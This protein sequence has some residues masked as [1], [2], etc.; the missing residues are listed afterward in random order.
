MAFDER[1]VKK[2]EKKHGQLPRRRFDNVDTLE[3]I[4]LY[5]FDMRHDIVLTK[6][7]EDV[8]KILEIADELLLRYY[9]GISLAMISSR[10]QKKIKDDLH[11]EREH[12]QCIT[13]VNQALNIF[14]EPVDV[15]KDKK[16]QLYIKRLNNIAVEAEKA[17]EY[18]AAVRALTKAAEIENFNK[19]GDETLK[20]LIKETNAKDIVFTSS[21]DELK[22][23]ASEIMENNA[24]DAQFE[25]DK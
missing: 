9:P 25:E 17:G 11:L 2:L 22:K 7:E 13:Y 19:D 5:Y 12:R 16:R 24:E 21:M 14:G 3:R 8:R 23:L 18:N 1:R 4:W 20:E 15:D 6:A 10:L